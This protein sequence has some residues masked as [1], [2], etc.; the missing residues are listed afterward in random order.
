M[1]RQTARSTIS[2]REPVIALKSFRYRG[3]NYKEGGNLDRRRCRMP[4]TKLVRLIRE[5][6]CI[7]ARDMDPE[8]L[9]EYGFIYSPKNPRLK[10]NPIPK[11]PKEP[12]VNNGEGDNIDEDDNSNVP[13]LKHTG[14]GWYDIMINGKQ[15][16]ETG[17]RK[18]DAQSFIDNYKGDE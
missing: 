18:D 17:L 9:A 16:N 15:I 13:T 4:H 7:L 14:G 12:P 1:R 10:L 6:A 2:R 3:R 8:R 11:E 5:G